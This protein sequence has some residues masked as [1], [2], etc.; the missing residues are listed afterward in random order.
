[1]ASN[2]HDVK[3]LTALQARL[4]Y[5]FSNIEHL[6]L[7]LTHSSYSATNN[8]RLEFLGDSV[9][10]LILS[11]ELFNTLP[12]ANPGTLTIQRVDCEN[13]EYLADIAR[14]LSIVEC[15]LLGRGAKRDGGGHSNSSL[16]GAMEALLAAV[17]L[18]SSLATVR[19]VVFAHVV[20]HLPIDK[21]PKT[22]LQER[23]MQQLGVLPSYELKSTAATSR[24]ATAQVMVQCVVDTLEL[25]TEGQGA[26]RKE[27]ETAAAI[28][29]LR[30][31]PA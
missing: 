7:A 2:P 28:E 11:E 31:V 9:L 16:A 12:S 8:E 20:P 29:M 30:L 26:N 5:T 3:L 6:K 21:H 4:G 10:R 27:A 18:D 23:L 17:Y 14:V 24:R 22:L 1:M 25:E 13:N 15:M 19:D